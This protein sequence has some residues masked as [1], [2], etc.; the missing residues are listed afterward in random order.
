MIA[1]RFWESSMMNYLY[2]LFVGLLISECKTAD[3]VLSPEWKLIWEDQFAEQGL[4]DTKKW[5]F[6]PRNSP[7]WAKYCTKSIR[8]TFVNNGKLH[9][10]GIKNTSDEDTVAYQTGCISTR[11]KFAFKYGK[12]EVKA[13]LSEGK[14]SWP[15]IWMMPSEGKYGGWPRSGEIDIMEHLNSDQK[16]YQT[17]HSSYVDLQNRKE[18][19]PYSTT[20]PINPGEYNV[21]GLEWYPDRLEFFVNGQKTFTYPKIDGADF[22]QWP[23]DQAF[24]LILDQALGG[25]WVG[26]IDDNDLP[27]EMTVDWVR[28][29]Q[30]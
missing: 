4:P 18:D 1:R 17:I 20:A 27:I 8:T 5:G 7:D 11:G 2:V 3:K 14:G 15:A 19:P 22:K 16:V 21:Y 25:S 26:K 12:V 13:K 10:R 23:F 24:Y 29:Y 30:K 28:I 9:L 6:A